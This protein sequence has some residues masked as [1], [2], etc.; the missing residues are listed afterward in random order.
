MNRRGSIII[1]IMTGLMVFIAGVIMIDFFKP[2]IDTIRD[3]S[4]LD[5]TNSTAISD[6][7]KVTCLLLDATIPYWIIIIL[8]LAGGFIIDRIT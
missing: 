8:A 3:S 7:T 5:C 1:G 6:G 4:V 2:E